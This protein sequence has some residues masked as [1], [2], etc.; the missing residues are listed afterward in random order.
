MI[1]VVV[2]HLSNRGISPSLIFIY[3][4]IIINTL[5]YILFFFSPLFF[6]FILSSLIICTVCNTMYML[7]IDDDETISSILHY[8]CQ[9]LYGRV[10]PRVPAKVLSLPQDAAASFGRSP[11]L[12]LAY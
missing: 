10:Y 2:L 11:Y 1:V 12:D 6:F 5:C 3:Y 4:F 7:L 9:L 8:G